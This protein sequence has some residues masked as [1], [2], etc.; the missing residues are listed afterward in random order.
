MAKQTPE[1][2]IHDLAAVSVTALR[3]IELSAELTESDPAAVAAA[4]QV[5]GELRRL[6]LAARTVD[7]PVSRPARQADAQ[8]YPAVLQLQLALTPDGRI[9]TGRRM[10]PL[11]G[12]TVAPMLGALRHEVK[13]LERE[14]GKASGVAPKDFAALV[15]QFEQE[16]GEADFRR[17]T[18]IGVV[19]EKT[20]P[21]GEATGPC[22]SPASVTAG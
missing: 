20:P 22:G 17:A 19:D 11:T 2:I 7:A 18:G 4:Y 15:D 14:A 3:R 16:A 6:I 1:Q 9:V 8:D 21:P 5:A 13:K 10:D 12:P